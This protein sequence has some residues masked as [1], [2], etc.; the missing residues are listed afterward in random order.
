MP[1]VLT[2]TSYWES[3]GQEVIWN[4]INTFVP[5]LGVVGN[6]AM[7]TWLQLVSSLGV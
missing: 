1:A 4:I 5:V 2:G 7:A 3:F 6:F